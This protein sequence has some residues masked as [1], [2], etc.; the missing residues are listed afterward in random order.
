[1]PLMTAPRK[2]LKYVP[3]LATVLM[4]SVL[5]YNSVQVEFKFFSHHRLNRNEPK[6]K[7]NDRSELS[8]N[9]CEVAE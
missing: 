1:M 6:K 2:L 3:H 8:L 5:L 4:C 7:K 9:T